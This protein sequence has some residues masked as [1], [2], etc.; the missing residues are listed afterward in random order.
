M[1]K[2]TETNAFTMLLAYKGLFNRTRAPWRI[3][4]LVLIAHRNGWEARAR[5]GSG[6]QINLEGDPDA[7]HSRRDDASDVRTE[8]HRTLQQA[9]QGGDVILMLVTESPA[10]SLISLRSPY[11]LFVTGLLF[12][13]YRKK[14]GSREHAIDRGL[15]YYDV[16]RTD[17][18]YLVDMGT[19][20][21]SYGL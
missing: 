19:I 14:T 8:F 5:E 11:L 18:S 16:L 1:D 4:L 13:T 6:V 2:Q 17:P 21:V 12:V 9:I 3:L 15:I 10:V 20:A 7:Y